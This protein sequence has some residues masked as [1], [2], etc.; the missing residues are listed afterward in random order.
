LPEENVNNTVDQLGLKPPCNSLAGM[1]QC[2][3]QKFHSAATVSKDHLDH[4][5][6]PVT[7]ES[8]ERMATTAKMEVTDVMDKYSRVLF[9]TSRASSAHLG[10]QATRVLQDKKDPVDRRVNQG[11]EA[12]M[13]TREPLVFRARLDPKAPRDRRD[14]QDQKDSQDDLSKSTA[15]LVPKDLLDPQ[16]PSERRESQARMEPTSAV[17][18]VHLGTMETPDQLGNLGPLDHPARLVHLASLAA[19]NTALRLVHHQATKWLAA[20]AII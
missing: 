10:P 13:A 12:K 5:V 19:A 14:H 6:H 18:L 7:T 1:A 3:H 8:L 11:K 9:H 16:D 15:P 2:R 4:L 17:W 20:A